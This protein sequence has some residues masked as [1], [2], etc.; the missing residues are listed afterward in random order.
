MGNLN[1]SYS[2]KCF[3]QHCRFY[4]YIKKCIKGPS[5]EAAS[6]NET[7]Q[8]IEHN[9]IEEPNGNDLKS[10]NKKSKIGFRERK[11]IEYENR[12][13]HYSTP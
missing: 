4:K 13:R 7:N 11:I 5:V 3:Y 12:I 1:C 6:I 8:D 2:Y 9:E 10:S